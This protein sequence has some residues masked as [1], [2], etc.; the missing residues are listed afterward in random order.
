MGDGSIQER[1]QANLQVYQT[2][3]LAISSGFVLFGIVMNLGMLFSLP[4]FALVLLWLAYLKLANS[5]NCETLQVGNIVLNRGHQKMI[6]SGITAFLL[7]LRMLP[8]LLLGAGVIGWHAVTHAP[9]A[10]TEEPTVD[11]D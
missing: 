11:M 6:L 7:L 10:L 3:Y 9:P 2:N 8:V 1:A 4:M 5:P